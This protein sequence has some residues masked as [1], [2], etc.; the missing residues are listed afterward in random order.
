M[1]DFDRAG[2]SMGN[3]DYL[4]ICTPYLTFLRILR[5]MMSQRPFDP[6]HVVQKQRRASWISYPF[7]PPSCAKRGRCC[8]SVLLFVHTF[9]YFLATQSLLPSRLESGG[10]KMKEAGE[11]EDRKTSSR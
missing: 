10:K 5:S 3:Y 1:D 7:S 6:F 9:S 11:G 4:L 2:G 8:P